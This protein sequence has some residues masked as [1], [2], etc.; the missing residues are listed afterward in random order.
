MV[1]L[2]LYFLRHAED[3]F[4]NLL[5]TLSRAPWKADVLSANANRAP[6]MEPHQQHLTSF[7]VL[8]LA[9]HYPSSKQPASENDEKKGGEV[10][11]SVSLSL[12]PDS[13]SGR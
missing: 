13:V 5:Q 3:G 4:H 10:P 2:G 9:N 12:V 6:G 1:P 7:P 11:P 8:P